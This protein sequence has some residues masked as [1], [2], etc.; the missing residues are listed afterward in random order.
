MLMA[1]AG[2]YITEEQSLWVNA[3][4]DS[5]IEYYMSGNGRDVSFFFLF[6]PVKT[7]AGSS[8]KTSGIRYKST[9]AYA[10]F[11]RLD[12]TSCFLSHLAQCQRG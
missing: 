11:R 10:G 12:A 8:V 6:Q 5:H 2:K 3:W 4:C 7:S 9:S 1:C